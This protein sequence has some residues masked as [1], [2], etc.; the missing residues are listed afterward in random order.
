MSAF[1]EA[2][3]SNSFWQDVS[4]HILVNA[5]TDSRILGLT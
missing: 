3:G 1:D 5:R 4:C 2:G